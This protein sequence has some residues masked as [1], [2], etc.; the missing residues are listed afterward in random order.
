MSVQ[1][2][3]KLHMPRQLCMAQYGVSM[4]A[5]DYCWTFCISKVQT[6]AALAKYCQTMHVASPDF[7]CSLAKMAKRDAQCEGSNTSRFLVHSEQAADIWQS[8]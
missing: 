6:P 4:I 8:S 1:I 7:L 5:A 3:L 2:D